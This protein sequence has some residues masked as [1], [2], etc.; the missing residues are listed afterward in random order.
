M[1]YIIISDLHANH[2][3]LRIFKD[4]LKTI[5]YDTIV[6]TGDL[7]GHKG[8]PIEFIKDFKSIKNTVAVKGNCDTDVLIHDQTIINNLFLH[9]Y[10]TA[11]LQ[12][13]Q[14]VN[15]HF[16]MCHGSIPF[17]NVYMHDINDTISSFQYLKDNHIPLLFFGHIH[18][19]KGYML[20]R[21]TS[22]ITEIKLTGEIE[23]NKDMLY[24][25]C[26]GSLGKP[27]ENQFFGNVLVYDSEKYTI[28][29][30]DLPI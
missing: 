11:I 18:I 29:R 15:E 12:G 10:F 28:Q 14:I 20:N 25:L 22:E 2:K 16:A 3:A 27:R 19:P 7:A 17:E 24:L 13:P 23:L 8:T 4:F 6:F 21:K 1:K 5:D 26:S 9:D 30:I